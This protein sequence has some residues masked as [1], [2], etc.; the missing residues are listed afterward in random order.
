MEQFG[1][2]IKRGGNLMQD[3]RKIIDRNKIKDICIPESFGDQI[4]FVILPFKEGVDDLW[5]WEPDD[6]EFTMFQ[7]KI[8]MESVRKEYGDEDIEKWK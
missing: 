3:I 6:V 5:N 4:E 7:H 1:L 2:K 8:N